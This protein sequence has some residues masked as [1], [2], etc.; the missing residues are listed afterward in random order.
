MS[1]CQWRLDLR[2]DL[3]GATN[4]SSKMDEAN[5]KDHDDVYMC[6]SAAAERSNLK[7]LRLSKNLLNFRVS[8]LLPLANLFA[9]M[10]LG[11]Y[12]YGCHARLGRTCCSNGSR[13]E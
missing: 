12:V 6:L 10:I 3:G 1:H 13:N 2:L 11:V 5:G 9:I 4:L 7:L 8:G